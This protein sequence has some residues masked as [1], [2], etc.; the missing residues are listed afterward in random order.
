MRLAHL[1]C[2]QN[3]KSDLPHCRLNIHLPLSISD[4]AEP[5]HNLSCDIPL[6]FM[7]VLEVGDEFFFRS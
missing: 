7:L 5:C 1:V 6:D 4:L 3:T 2:P